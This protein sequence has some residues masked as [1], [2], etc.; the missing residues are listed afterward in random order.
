MKLR[1]KRKYLRPK[2]KLGLPISSKLRRQ[3]SRVFHRPVHSVNTVAALTNSSR[4][5][6]PSRA[7]PSARQWSLVLEQQPAGG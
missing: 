2:T 7:F 3:W 4:G 6:V 1:K 5:I